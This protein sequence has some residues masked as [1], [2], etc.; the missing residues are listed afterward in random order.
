MTE[1][2]RFD[3]KVAIVT[4]A[5]AG[6][7]RSHA[8]ALAARGARV[9]VND[10]GGGAHGGGAGT[11]A[12]DA[13]VA[14]IVAAGG[15]AA[16]N[17][18][19]VENGEAIAQAAIDAFGTVDILINNAGILR[20]VS[21]QK[22]S[23]QDWD[24]IY[25]VHLLG[26][27]RVTQAVWPILRDKQ[28]GRI[29]MTTSAAGLYGNFGQA[30]YSA[31]KL[32]VVGL[33]QTL[34]EE[35]RARNIHVNV[36]APV[37]AS[38]LLS[39]VLPQEVL[40]LLKPE[41]VTALV[42]WLC[43]ERCDQTKG[44][45]EVGA[46]YVGKLRWQR[47]GGVFFPQGGLGPEQMQARWGEIADFAAP[48]YPTSTTE[49]VAPILEGAAKPRLGGNEFIDLDAASA[50]TLEAQSSY[51]E[52]DLA[53]YALGVGAARDALDPQELRYVYELGD[54]FQAVP[55]YAVM[56]A[57]NTFLNLA[58]D[59]RGLKG[60]NYGLDRILHGEQYTELLRPLPPK[61]QLTH[62]FAFKTAYDKNPHAVVVIGCDSF[63]ESGEKL[64]Y[65]EISLF[66]RGAGGWGGERGP[67]S[68]R[69]AAPDREPDA[70]VEERTDPNQ[71]L[72]YRLSGDWNPMHADPAFARAFGFDRPIL[73]G[74]CTYG[75]VARHV[76]RSFAGND[77]RRFKSIRVRFADSVF[78]GETLVTR[79]WRDGENRFV[80]ET[81][82][83][84][85]DKLVVSHAALELGEP[86]QAAAASSPPAATDTPE[87]ANHLTAVE[88]FE[89]IGEH[90]ARH[91]ELAS[92]V[93]T[94]FQFKVHRPD[95]DWV[96]D[97]RNGAGECRPGVAER[98]DCTLELDEEHVQTL[99]TRPIGEVQKLYFGG[100][101]KIAGNLMASQKLAALHAIGTEPFARVQARRAGATAQAA[102]QDPVAVAAPLEATSTDLFET[103]RRHIADN[104]GLGDQVRTRFQF[105]LHRPESQWFLDLKSGDGT[106]AEGVDESADATLELDDADFV[107]MST[108]HA[109]AQK[110]YFGGKLK[111]AGNIMAS[112]KLMFLQK[113]DPALLQ[114]VLAERSSAAVA[115]GPAPRGPAT[116][117]QTDGAPPRASDLPRLFAELSRHW[118][119]A[120][121]AP[122]DWAGCVVSF[123]V[124]APESG[125]TA[126]LREPKPSIRSSISQAATATFHIN[127]RDLSALFAG[128]ARAHDLFQRGR[129][130]VEGELR[131]AHSLDR[132]AAHR[133]EPRSAAPT[134]ADRLHE[135]TQA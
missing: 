28:Y 6:L 116:R 18:D 40:D 69:N 68:E 118:E 24:L 53:L 85:R 61:A 94:V 125:W 27:M 36:I 12:A 21:F 72:L 14:E 117:A 9:L 120:G 131:L 98:A 126:D 84:E 81:K 87:A 78:P 79:I 96:L 130:R 88:A 15:Q 39:T 37:A 134:P 35:G 44:L 76:L 57:L 102:A 107:A 89:V 29:V 106:V 92:Q 121:D 93:A 41:S 112:Q 133:A 42:A 3:G 64:A 11:H 108:G 4:G 26:S 45:F 135:D 91:P 23:E 86:A 25:R 48:T 104:P 119:T 122:P 2:L 127:D 70:V 38:R 66:V 63:D 123:Q 17:Y 10:L 73:H 58:R 16:A 19:S 60:L 75:F 111:I 83:K 113:I 101:L 13:V 124:D 100:Q 1:T 90:V 46:G 20:D 31:A 99:V 114:A 34:A 55:T 43:H 54:Q 59:G 65:N 47:S 77:G 33:A 129:L 115:T 74:L 97:L 82:V 132:L 62:R 110:L 5:G 109:D 52:R 30:N 71:A 32:A 103:I 105:K 95:S 50:D 49:S 8:L 80:F 128:T 67:S 56:P 22:M 7:G 51:D